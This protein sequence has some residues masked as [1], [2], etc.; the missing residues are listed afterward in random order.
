MWYINKCTYV[1]V[2]SSTIY[3]K[4]LNIKIHT[5]LFMYAYTYLNTFAYFVRYKVIVIA[6]NTL[7]FFRFISAHSNTCDHLKQQIDFTGSKI[8][9]VEI[10]ANFF[11]IRLQYLHNLSNDLQENLDLVWKYYSNHYFIHKHWFVQKLFV[12]C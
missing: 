6:F 1:L 5:Y 3:L 8:A 10:S 7:W 12:F 2:H 11:Y 9:M 4:L